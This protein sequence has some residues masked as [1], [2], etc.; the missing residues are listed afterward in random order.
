[1]Q[2]GLTMQIGESAGS[3]DTQGRGWRRRSVETEV[4]SSEITGSRVL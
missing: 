3:A 1:M 2:D 4:Y